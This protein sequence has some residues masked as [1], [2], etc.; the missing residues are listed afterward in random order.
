MYV[1]PPLGG[2]RAAQVFRLKAGLRTERRCKPF[3]LSSAKRRGYQ[4]T[5]YQWRRLSADER[6]E[7]LAARKQH[8]LPWHRPP[9]WK[10]EAPARFHISAACYEHT[11]VIGRSPARMDAFAN[12]LTGACA[13]HETHLFA[14]CLL[15]NHYHL[16]VELSDLGKFIRELGKLHGGA[17][18]TWNLEECMVGRKIFH[19]AAD[20]HIRSEGHFWATLNYIHHNPVHHGYVERW[21]NWPWSS[22]QAYLDVVGHEQ[23]ARVWREY[24]VLDYGKEWDGPEM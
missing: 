9:H 15:P 8:K 23:A 19:G 17:S 18:R 5:M 14:W 12:D 10:H 7:L 20:R 11:P 6:T 24:P 21:T 22:A 16:L 1:V 3:R 13:A 4:P 2:I